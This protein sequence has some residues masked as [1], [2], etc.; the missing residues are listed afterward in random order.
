VGEIIMGRASTGAICGAAAVLIIFGLAASGVWA[1]D[2]LLDRPVTAGVTVNPV[3]L[4][5]TAHP[6]AGWW[7]ST[8]SPSPTMAEEEMVTATAA[9]SAGWS[10]TPSPTPVDLVGKILFK[11]RRDRLVEY[12]YMDADGANQTKMPWEM[13]DRY[14]Q[15][16]EARAR[17]RDGQHVVYVGGSQN[18]GVQELSSGNTWQVTFDTFPSYDP[19]I[20]SDGHWIV[21]VSQEGGSGQNDEIWIIDKN[22]NRRQQL[23]FTDWEWNKLPSWSPDG[24]QIV[25]WSNRTGT[26]QIY[27]MNRDGSGLTQLTFEGANWDAVWV[28]E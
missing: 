7:E 6:T 1:W 10:P 26:S 18:I 24:S 27:V 17:S 19:A 11:T 20:S 9:W 14:F 2:S 28:R 4:S 15:A 21:F 8:P 25:F 3:E 22:G 13:R 5:A 23:T 12:W 16:R